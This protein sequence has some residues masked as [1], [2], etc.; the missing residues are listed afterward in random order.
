M[1]TSKRGLTPACSRAFAFSLLSCVFLSAAQAR[2]GSIELKGL[3]DLPKET[4]NHEKF[5]G[6]ILEITTDREYHLIMK[7]GDSTEL[8]HPALGQPDRKIRVTFLEMNTTDYSHVLIDLDGK[9]LWIG[10][11][12]QSLPEETG[13]RAFTSVLDK[14][15]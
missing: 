10:L 9:P 6:A 7:I 12:A 4:K 13:D 5:A 8:P 2:G 14:L 15:L 1:N 11:Y 3:F